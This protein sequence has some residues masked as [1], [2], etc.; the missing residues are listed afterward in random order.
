MSEDIRIHL[1]CVININSD[2]DKN[3]EEILNNI[4]VNLRSKKNVAIDRVAFV[5]CKQKAM[6]SLINSMLL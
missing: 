3:T 2:T 5:E 1:R 6:K 4:H